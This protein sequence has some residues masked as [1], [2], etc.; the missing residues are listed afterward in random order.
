MSIAGQIYNRIDTIEPGKVIGYNYFNFPNDK[1]EALAAALTR[2]TKKGI[3]KRLS[4]GLYYKPKESE[5]GKLAP[6]E[7]QI[8]KKYLYV[9]KK[10]IGYLTGINIYN[11]MGLTTQIANTNTVAYAVP[12]R[13]VSIGRVKIDFV[14]AYGKI[15]EGDIEY[16]QFLDAVKD[17]KSIPDNDVNTVS[18]ILLGKLRSMKRAERKRIFELSF[19]YNPAT[20]ALAG[21]L[22]EL[23]EKGTFVRQL[24]ETLN[25]LTQYKIGISEDVLPNKESWNIK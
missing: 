3:I 7:D 11:R 8:I 14:K 15:S 4:K 13:E 1:F 25:G 19:F 17:I 22:L 10:R 24:K 2:F 20:R 16:L 18:R 23:T 12:R 9:G 6:N 5:F 21:A